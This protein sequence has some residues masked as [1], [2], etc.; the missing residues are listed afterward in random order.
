[1]SPLPSELVLPSCFPSSLRDVVLKNELD[2]GPPID[3]VFKPASPVG[4]GGLELLL[5][6]RPP[7]RYGGAE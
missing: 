2:V 6:G 1:M 5:R 4:V 3:C 7:K